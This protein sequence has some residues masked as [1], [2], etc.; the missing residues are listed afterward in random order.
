MNATAPVRLR[1]KDGTVRVTFDALDR[2]AVHAPTWEAAA[3]GLGWATARHRRTQMDLLRRRS[4]GRLAEVLG[5]QA[6]PAD[7]RQRTLGLPH[8]ARACWELLPPPQRRTLAAYAEGVNAA[9][10]DGDDE[11]WVPVDCVAVAQQLLQELSSDGQDVRMVEVMRRTLAPAV[12]QFLLDGQ[13][14]FAV[15]IDG[16]VPAPRR[17]ALPVAEVKTLMA[18]PPGPP[19][20]LVVA[21]RRPVGSN[22]WAV[23]QGGTAVLANDMHLELT[24]PSL[25]YAV[26]LVVRETTVDGVTVPGL[27]SLVAG[28]NGRVAWGFTR[29][30][31]DTCELRELTPGSTPGTYWHGDREERFTVRRERVTVRGADDVEVDVHETPWGPVV[32]RLR[33]RPLVFGGNLTDPTALDFTLTGLY[34]VAT[35]TEAADLLNDCGM[36]PLNAVLADAAGDIAWTVTGR[37]PRRA[38]GP[39]G[40]SDPVRDPWPTPRLA[41]HELPRLLTPPSGYVVSCNNADAAG[42]TAALGWNFFPGTRARRAAEALATAGPHDE[43]H[44][45]ALQ[46]DLDAA[47]YTYYRDLALRHL[48]ERGPSPL[49]ALRDE[50]LAWRGT[51][52]HDEYGLALLVVFRELLREELFAALTRPCRRY[53]EA[54]TYC[55]NGHEGPL[56]RLLD[57]LAPG[58]VPA[59]WPGPAPFV[60]GMLGS[61]RALLTRRTGTAEPVRWGS[62]NVLA[63]TPLGARSVTGP[64]AGSEAGLSGCP[65]SL[66]VTQP[67]FGAAMRLVVAP[68]RPADGLL[69]IP[70][71]PSGAGP[72]ERE[73]LARWTAGRSHPLSPSGDAPHRAPDGAHRPEPLR[74]PPGRTP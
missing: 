1:T 21:D 43:A 53:D 54:F 17:S 14:E 22:A 35:V 71:S 60:I 4:H 11:P 24:S 27:P 32:D 56:R 69:T 70:G 12:V 64:P 3:F 28:S 10:P 49:R 62:V 66:R 45:A 52:H 19:G 31:A 48:P 13:D 57:A 50:V 30:P 5:P 55:Y 65:E 33:G 7:V 63:P 39:R 72:E 23:A 2:P 40:F 18:E 20:P 47:L 25:M 41:P 44:S 9:A 16:T 6:V 38:G 51:S 58:L 37:H 15:G 67:D 42:R 61:A 46:L 74:T 8:V 26:R 34:E 68:A 59:P 73:H 29:L 36:P